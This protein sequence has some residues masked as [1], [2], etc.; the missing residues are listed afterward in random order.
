MTN[1]YL[2]YLCIRP[3][4]PCRSDFQTKKNRKQPEVT[5]R[6]PGIFSCETRHGHVEVIF[7]ICST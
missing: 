2:E 6:Y 4:N 7:K 1:Q 3:D 5:S